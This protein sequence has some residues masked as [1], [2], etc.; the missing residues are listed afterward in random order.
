MRKVSWLGEWEICGLGRAQSPLLIVLLFSSWS[1]VHREWLSNRFTLGGDRWKVG[2]LEGGRHLSPALEALVK[3]TQSCPTLW[4]PIDCSLAGYS[5][6]GDSPGQNTGVS[7]CSFLQGIFPIQGSNPG[8]LHCRRI[9]F[10][11]S[12]QGSARSFTGIFR[13]RHRENI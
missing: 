6:H 5:V 4:D 10:C 13:S 3:V 11:L 1:L 7:S 12:H 9:L 8:L 2:G